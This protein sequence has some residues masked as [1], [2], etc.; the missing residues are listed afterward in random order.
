MLRTSFDRLKLEHDQFL[1]NALIETFC[2]HARALLEFY[3]GS[4]RRNAHARLFTDKQYVCLDLRP[5]TRAKKLKDMLDQQLSHLSLKRDSTKQI[6]VPERAELFELI[7][8]EHQ[9]FKK[10]L[11]S[12][13]RDIASEPPLAEPVAALRQATTTSPLPGSV[14]LIHL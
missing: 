14:P 12:K 13:W 2:L 11:T 6:D 7:N 3:A 9:R 8:N 1:N 4:N 10:H 5:G